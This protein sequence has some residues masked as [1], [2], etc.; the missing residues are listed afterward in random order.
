M[1]LSCGLCVEFMEWIVVDGS[2]V[3]EVCGLGET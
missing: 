3:L 1:G 2:I